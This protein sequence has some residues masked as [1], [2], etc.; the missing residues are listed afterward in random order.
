MANVQL[1]VEVA[2]ATPTQQWL[3]CVQVPIGSTVAEAIRL[4]DIFI[5]CPELAQHQP[6]RVGIFSKP[7][8][9]ESILEDQQRIEIY[10]P[11]MCDPKQARR[12][13]VS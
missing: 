3:K 13:R 1:Y 6:L 10:R 9:L 2:Y 5:D 4:S 7:C 11:L 8:H 12:K